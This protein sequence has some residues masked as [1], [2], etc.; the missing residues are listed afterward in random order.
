MKQREV[1]V[2]AE[3]GVNHEGSLERCLG[4][5]DDAKWAGADAVKLQIMS[6]DRAYA[7][8]TESYTVFKSSQLSYEDTRRVYEHCL[9]IGLD[10]GATFGDLGSVNEFE[11]LAWSFHKISSGLIDYIEQVRLIANKFPVAPIFVSTGMSSFDEID[12]VMDKYSEAIRRRIVLLQCTSLYPCP[13]DQINLSAIPQLR[14]RYEV[15]VGFSDHSQSIDI[16]SYAVTQGATVIEKHFTFD[17]SRPGFDHRI[18]LNKYQFHRMVELIHRV[19]GILG[20][21]VKGTSDLC[22][23]SNLRNRRSIVASRDLERGTVICQSDLIA[24]RTGRSSDLRLVDMDKYIGRSL[25]KRI[26]KF[27]QISTAD[28]E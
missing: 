4:L 14:D 24:M 16:P 6:P 1:Y 28:F 8:E 7:K 22:V 2:V 13:D 11:K 18:S 25:N 23:V 10:L 17:A 5:C 26:S 20:S 19:K 15:R 12:N 27:N 21:G 3:I 9:A